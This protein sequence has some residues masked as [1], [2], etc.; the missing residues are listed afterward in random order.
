MIHL[1]LLWSKESGFCVLNELSSTLNHFLIRFYYWRQRERT[2]PK[3]KPSL[4]RKTALMTAYILPWADVKTPIMSLIA[5][6][7]ARAVSKSS[8]Q[9]AD[10]ASRRALASHH[11]CHRSQHALP[12]RRPPKNCSSGP[13]KTIW[14][15]PLKKQRFECPEQASKN[16]TP[17]TRIFQH[18][19]CKDSVSKR[20]LPIAG[21]CRWQ[22]LWWCGCT[23]FIPVV[24]YTVFWQAEI[25]RRNGR[26]GIYLSSSACRANSTL[27]LVLLQA[28]WA[29]MV[30]FL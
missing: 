5:N 27:S 12:M 4:M 24:G 1:D 13:L 7:K 16:L 19:L 20:P 29:M 23:D 26:N 21:Y 10:W 17:I 28:T 22:S 8:Q 2:D 15:S 18:F 30:N 9:S 3:S 6:C 11:R 25:D 14:S